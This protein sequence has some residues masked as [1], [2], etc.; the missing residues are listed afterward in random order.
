MVFETAGVLGA[1]QRALDVTS[2]GGTTVLVGLNKS[3]QPL[4][5]VDV[6]LREIT[7]RSTVAQICGSDI[8]QALSLLASAEMSRLLPTRVISLDEMVTAG[9]EPLTA[10]QVQGKSLVDPRDG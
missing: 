3:V 6:V 10:G 8:P 7:V 9:L 1:A 2:R 4:N 5:L